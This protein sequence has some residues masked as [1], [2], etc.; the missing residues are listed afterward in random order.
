[1]TT[2]LAKWAQSAVTEQADIG[3]GGKVKRKYF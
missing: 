1:M 3:G 2:Q